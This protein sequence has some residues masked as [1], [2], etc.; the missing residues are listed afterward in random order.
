MSLFMKES[1]HNWV[2]ESPV[3]PQR[4]G[5]H[6]SLLK[7]NLEIFQPQK[8]TEVVG[9]FLE[10]NVACEQHFLPFLNLVDPSL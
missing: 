9:I 1:P 3:C 7:L 10:E 5:A 8:E 4:L 2:E 6:F